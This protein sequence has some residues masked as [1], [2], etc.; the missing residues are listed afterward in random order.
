MLSKG[1]LEK[2]FATYWDEMDRCRNTGAYWALLHITVCM[3][4]ICGA[5]ESSDGEASKAK[6]IDWFDRY[7]SDS[8][9]NGDECYRMRC[10]VLHQAR[11]L[12]DRPGRYLGFAFG[13]PSND[14]Q[15]YHKQINKNVLHLDVGELEKELRIG[16][17]KWIND[18]ESLR[19]TL[20]SNNV[21]NNIREVVRVT[22]YV[23]PQ[24]PS[25]LSGI[26]NLKTISVTGSSGKL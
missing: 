16:I 24:Q 5:L 4:D 7:W 11:S 14:G 9:L 6:Y 8:I 19:D 2:V 20:N 10:K 26:I 15:I 18:M 21:E 3:P 25:D 13:Q 1:D 17:K 23:V 12:T 22:Q